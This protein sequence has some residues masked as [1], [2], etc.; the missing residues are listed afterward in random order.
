MI[1][2]CYHIFQRRKVV[3]HAISSNAKVL[4]AVSQR[5]GS[6]IQMMIVVTTLMSIIVVSK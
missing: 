6:V 3:I 1:S 2:V 4:V 5:D